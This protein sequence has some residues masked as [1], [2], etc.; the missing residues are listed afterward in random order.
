VKRPPHCRASNAASTEALLLEILLMLRAVGGPERTRTV[1]AE[2]QRLGIDP[3]TPED[4]A[5]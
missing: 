2:L 1:R 3:W 5:A 4:R